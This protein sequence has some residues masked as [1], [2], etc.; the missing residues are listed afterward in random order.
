MRTFR[1]RPDGAR[2]RIG[3]AI[4]ALWLAAHTATLMVQ[5]HLLNPTTLG[6]PG[7][8]DVRSAIVLG[9]VSGLLVAL[10]TGGVLLYRRKQAP[11]ASAAGRAKDRAVAG[12]PIGRP[13]ASDPG[14]LLA[15]PGSL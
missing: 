9:L 7:I 10:L 4:V 8:G 6:A 1:R 3:V 13:H 12:L 15:S 11:S 5:L 2:F 14:T